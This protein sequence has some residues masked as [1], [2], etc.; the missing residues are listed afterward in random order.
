MVSEKRE[1]LWQTLYLPA[2]EEW[3]VCVRETIPDIN[4]DANIAGH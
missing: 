3:C 4:W 1:R 2:T